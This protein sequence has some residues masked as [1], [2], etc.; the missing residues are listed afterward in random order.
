M[1]HGIA[2]N[3]C[4]Y[5]PFP[6]GFI[7]TLI[8]Y[9]RGGTDRSP[10]TTSLA[11]IK[12]PRNFQRRFAVSNLML[13]RRTLQAEEGRTLKIRVEAGKKGKGK[14]NW[15]ENASGEDNREE[16]HG[17]GGLLACHEARQ[18]LRERFHLR[19]HSQV[20]L[21]SFILLLHCSYFT[22]FPLI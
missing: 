14:R 9:R 2:N 4:I 21:L 3:N 8:V 1:Q 11:H 7:L 5:L 13:D 16:F 10:K 12:L 17:H 15:S 18:A 22:L 6:I 19:S 20:L